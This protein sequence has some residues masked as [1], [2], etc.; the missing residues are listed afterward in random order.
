MKPDPLRPEL[1]LAST[2]GTEGYGEI[3]GGG[4]R[5]A[6]LDLML[7][8]IEEHGL[9]QESFEWYLDLRRYGFGAALRFRHGHRTCRRLDF[10]SSNT[11]AKRFRIPDAL[12]S[13]PVSSGH[14]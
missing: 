2:S 13:V 12:S 14:E 10:G 7:Q 6:D 1:A 4:E 9:P 3:I 8:R 11:F 5:L